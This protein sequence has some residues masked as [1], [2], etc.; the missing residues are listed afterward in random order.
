[1]ILNAVL[2]VHANKQQKIFS[3]MILHSLII[4][5]PGVIVASKK[6]L[7][8]TSYTRYHI[9]MMSFNSF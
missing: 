7:S 9:P 1:M 2:A 5:L 3:R 6:I 8:F 4:M